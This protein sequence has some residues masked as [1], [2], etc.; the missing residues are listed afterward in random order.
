MIVPVSLR[1]PRREEGSD[2]TTEGGRG[3]EAFSDM[4]GDPWRVV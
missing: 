3:G 1:N 4:D 2:G